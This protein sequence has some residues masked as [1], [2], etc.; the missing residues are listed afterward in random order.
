MAT[1][2]PCGPPFHQ[3]SGGVPLS[4]CCEAWAVRLLSAGGVE[5]DH[6]DLAFGLLLVIGVGRPELQRLFPQPRARSSP[7]AVRAP[8]F[9][10]AV[11]TCTSTS[12]L[13]RMLR[14]QPGVLRC[15]AFRCDDEIA[16][17]GVAVERREDEP[18][19]RFPAGRRQQQRRDCDLW[20]ARWVTLYMCP[21]ASPLDR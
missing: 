16:V 17:T 8:A 11:P 19:F 13:A 1:H 20:P 18:S 5:H 9:V 2:P 4:A 14:Y 21:S 12:G 6:G 10:F 15:A 7:V 3:R